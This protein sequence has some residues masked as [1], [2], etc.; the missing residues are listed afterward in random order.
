MI[1]SKFKVLT[2]SL[3]MSILMSSVMSFTMLVF[4]MESL[5]EVFT[6]WPS[7]WAKSALFAFPFSLIFLRITQKLTAIIVSDQKGIA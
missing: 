7:A 1:P 3:I 5:H 6:S 4:Q 2:F